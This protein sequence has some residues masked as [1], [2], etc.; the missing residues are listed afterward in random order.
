MGVGLEIRKIDYQRHFFTSEARY[1]ISLT[2]TADAPK[3][4]PHGTAEFVSHIEHGPFPKG[5]LAHGQSLPTL[6]FLHSA[7][8]DHD[9]LQP[10]IPLTPCSHPPR[11]QPLHHSTLP[12]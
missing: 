6:P 4:M 7:L 8:V 10:L 5:A 11:T 1:G 3:D 12:T 9:D 2:K